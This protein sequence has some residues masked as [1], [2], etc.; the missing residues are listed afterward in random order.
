MQSPVLSFVD[1]AHAATTECLDA[2]AV[3]DVLA[4]HE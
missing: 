4:D 2:A 1:D 3:R